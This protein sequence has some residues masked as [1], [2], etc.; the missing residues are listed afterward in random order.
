MGSTGVGGAGFFG[1]CGVG[2]GWIR[3]GLGCWDGVGIGVWNAAG[4]VASGSVHDIVFCLGNGAAVSG[5][6]DTR[7]SALNEFGV[8]RGMSVT[9]DVVRIG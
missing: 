5:V 8:D 9:V 3:C 6:M 7:P 4:T 2:S 1:T